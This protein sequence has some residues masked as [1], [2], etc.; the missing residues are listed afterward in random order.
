LRPGGL[1]YLSYNAMP[2]WARDLPFHGLVREF[3]RKFP[4]DS[5]A[6]VAFTGDLARTLVDSGVSALAAS[7]I[8]KELKERPGEYTPAYLVHE[9]MPAAWQPLYVTEVRAAMATIN[10]NPVGSATLSEN[11]DWILLTEQ[12]REKLAA[13]TDA[14]VRDYYLDQ[15][16][17][18]DV[19]GRGNRQLGPEERAERI[20]WGRVCA[21]AAAARD[22]L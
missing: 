4:D 15:R 5:A 9:F 22:P 11:F 21:R 13:I 12:A 3:G 14:N 1:V 17:R 16:F 7:F 20:L 10:L 8:V 19:F 6:Q 2:G 18:C